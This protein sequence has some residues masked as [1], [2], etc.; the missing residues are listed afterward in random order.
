[1]SRKSR[2]TVVGIVLTLALLSVGGCPE[3]VDINLNLGGWD[4]NRSGIDPNSAWNDPAVAGQI[5]QSL[6]NDP[7]ASMA[8]AFAGDSIAAKRDV[9]PLLFPELDDLMAAGPTGAE[10]MLAEF[11]GNPSFE[12]DDHL[13]LLAYALE[14]MDYYP[15]L[16]R[17]VDFL[18]ENIT[19]AVPVTTAEVTHAIRWMVGLPLNES[20]SY[21]AS[22][23][24]ET[25][26]VARAD[27]AFR[28]R[29]DPAK[30]K[31][32]CLRQFVLLDANGQPLMYPGT[33]TPIT[34]GGN[35]WPA[36]ADASLS[37]QKV[38]DEDWRVEHG[39]GTRVSYTDPISGETF[40]G[41]PTKCF[42]CAGFAFR[43]F[44]DGMKWTA[45]P[46]DWFR[47]LT[48]ADALEPVYEI[49]SQ[50]GDFV[51]YYYEGS[52]IPSHVA[53][54]QGNSYG[55]PYAGLSST[56]GTVTV[57]NA[58]G[59]S[60]LFT[61]PIGASYFYGNWLK[62]Y[63]QQ[64]LGI[65]L[66]TILN[67]RYARHEVWRWKGGQPPRFKL[68][69]DRNVANSCHGE[70]EDGDGFP[71][72][73]TCTSP[74]SRCIDPEFSS[75]Q[76]GSSSTPGYRVYLL[77]QIGRGQLEVL[78]EATADAGIPLCNFSGGGLDCTVMAQLDPITE[79]F[80]TAEEAVK[81]LCGRVTNIIVEPLGIGPSGQLDGVSRYLGGAVYS[82]LLTC[83]Q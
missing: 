56:G 39:G 64:F 23:I 27:L 21:Q 44:N 29:V 81:S 33:S 34:V 46:A 68:Y 53:V 48:A 58:D 40:E 42:N 1:M 75:G 79:S 25:I 8:S 35:V 18:D 37:A 57:I 13:F 72:S 77:P 74:T 3:G 49:T 55:T 28:S 71:E 5:V 73:P 45:A 30:L 10:A 54:V 14:R 22:E 32:S 41:R 80:P 36:D 52:D 60:G 4:P 78:D 15:G 66:G 16:D 67:Q 12:D 70:D 24:E 26:D 11:V 51:F 19:G 50:P 65:D 61:A 17:L 31:A 2:N 82:T 63:A 38:N 43:S 59:Q 76:G 69:T 20:A 9:M 7:L 6:M 62:E 47:A 83:G